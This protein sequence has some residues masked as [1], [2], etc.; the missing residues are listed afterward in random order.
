LANYLGLAR[1][2]LSRKLVQFEEDGLIELIGQKVVRILD[3][4]RLAGLS[5]LVD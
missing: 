3:L 4:E 5:V 1:E 2:T